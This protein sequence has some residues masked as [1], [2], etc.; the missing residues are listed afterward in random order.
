MAD[1]IA[2]FHG[3]IG[4]R[5]PGDWFAKESLTFLAPDGQAN[6]IVS[7]EALDASIDTAQYAD[8]IMAELRKRTGQQVYGAQVNIFGAPAVSGLGRAGVARDARRDPP[9]RPGCARL[10]TLHARAA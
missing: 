1:E 9:G 6:V 4:A 7:N 5:M 3:R 8:N 2:T 10:P